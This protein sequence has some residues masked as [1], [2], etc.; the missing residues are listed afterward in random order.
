M[1][2]IMIVVLMMIMI[3]VVVV[4]MIVAMFVRMPVSLAAKVHGALVEQDG[5][6]PYDGNSR[7]RAQYR[8]DL[9]RQ[10]VLGKEESDESQKKDADCVCECHHA[11]EENR[12]FGGPPRTH[13]IGRHNG[14]PMT[15]RK[16]VN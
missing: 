2:M 1:M 3:V 9:L 15:R 12:M 5:A 6:D 11:A 8:I 7:N 13:E 10:H 16:R 14:F 4:M